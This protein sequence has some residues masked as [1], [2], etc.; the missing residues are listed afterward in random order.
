MNNKVITEITSIFS[1]LY[2]F[3]FRKEKYNN[4]LNLTFVVF[5]K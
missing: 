3:D 1:V 4:H 5:L 2:N